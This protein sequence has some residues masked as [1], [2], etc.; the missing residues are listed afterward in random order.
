ME[1]GGPKE[2]AALARLATRGKGHVK[3][4]ATSPEALAGITPE[5]VRGVWQGSSWPE[6]WRVWADNTP[7]YIRKRDGNTALLEL[8]QLVARA[9]QANMCVEL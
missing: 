3:W 7:R 2:W 8:L 9:A 5:V 6:V 1:K 4:L